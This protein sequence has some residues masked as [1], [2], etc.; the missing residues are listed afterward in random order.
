MPPLEPD[1]ENEPLLN[2][3]F[4]DAA[5][6]G[7]EVVADTS[8]PNPLVVVV[9]GAA[10]VDVEEDIGT[11]ELELGSSD[12]GGLCTLLALLE[13]DSEGPKGRLAAQQGCNGGGNNFM[14]IQTTL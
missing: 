5:D 4:E 10:E 12:C 1:P 7:F 14:K 13:E 9:T 2:I 8:D 11:V 6:K 3:G